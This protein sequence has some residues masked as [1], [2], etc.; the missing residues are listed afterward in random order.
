M[1]PSSSYTLSGWVEG[2]YVFIGDSGTGTSDTDNW[3]PSAPGWQQLSTTFTTGASTTSVT[4]YVH[5][6]YAQGTYFADDLSLSG[7]G[8]SGGGGGG[9]D[10]ARGARPG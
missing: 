5:G 8:G 4:I 1:Q 3:T 9:G 2:N 6:W 10:G 7:P